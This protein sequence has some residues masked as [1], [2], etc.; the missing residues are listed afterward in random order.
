MPQTKLLASL[1]CALINYSNKISSCNGAAEYLKCKFGDVCRLRECLWLY[2]FGYI[3]V[4]MC[5]CV[6]VCVCVVC[7]CV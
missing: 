1:E 6:C 7:V 3:E 4:C 2:L 5:V